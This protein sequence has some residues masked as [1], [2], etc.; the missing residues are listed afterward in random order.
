MNLFSIYIQP[1]NTVSY[2]NQYTEAYGRER[3]TETVRMDRE[4]CVFQRWET[5]QY[6]G[7]LGQSEAGS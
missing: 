1:S 4:R 2:S 6:K 5:T 7:T 3:F